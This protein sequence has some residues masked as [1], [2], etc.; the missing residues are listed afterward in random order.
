MRAEM[1]VAAAGG[2]DFRTPKRRN[3]YVPAGRMKCR[4]SHGGQSEISWRAAGRWRRSGSISRGSALTAVGC[5]AADR[6]RGS[7]PIHRNCPRSGGRGFAV[8]ARRLLLRAGRCLQV[9]QTGELA[10]ARWQPVVE[11]RGGLSPKVIDDV[12]L[13]EAWWAALPGGWIQYPRGPG[14]VW[15]SGDLAASAPTGEIGARLRVA[16]ARR[17]ATPGDCLSICPVGS[18]APSPASVPRCRVRME[19]NDCGLPASAADLNDR[20]DSIPSSLSWLRESI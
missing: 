13:A 5:R 19:I 6:W 2:A 9:G 17:R 10:E 18:V 12:R 4:R 3:A 8:A 1:P 7:G 15:P 14:G 11:E 16:A 20:P